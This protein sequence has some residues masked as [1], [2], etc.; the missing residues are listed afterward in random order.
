[1]RNELLI[2]I[3]IF[4]ALVSL[5]FPFVF[6]VFLYHQAFCDPYNTETTDPINILQNHHVIVFWCVPF[7]INC[8]LHYSTLDIHKRLLQCDQDMWVANMNFGHCLYETTRLFGPFTILILHISV[9]W[10]T[11]L[12]FFNFA[13]QRAKL[14]CGLEKNVS[15]QQI[16]SFFHS[17]FCSQKFFSS[18]VSTCMLFHMLCRLFGSWIC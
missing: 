6:H 16:Y 5:S 12:N 13:D 9:L 10:N 14:I 15:S 18:F 8:K 4:A 7:F 17:G 2:G 11:A 3:A 1:M